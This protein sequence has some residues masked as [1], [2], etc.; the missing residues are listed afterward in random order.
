MTSETEE[1]LLTL[2]RE[3]TPTATDHQLISM[4][5]VDVKMKGLVSAL[6]EDGQTIIMSFGL[7]FAP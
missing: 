3:I 2:A 4:G 5:M 7:D 1:Y 6:L